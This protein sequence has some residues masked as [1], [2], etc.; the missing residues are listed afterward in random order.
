M[1]IQAFDTD[2]SPGELVNTSGHFGFNPDP[3]PPELEVTKLLSPLTEA[4]TALGRLQGIGSNIDNPRMLINPFIRKEAV[5]S[6]RIEGTRAT[7][8]DVYAYEAGD[9]D[10]VQDTIRGDVR[11]VLNYVRAMEQGL[12]A[13]ENTSITVDLIRS[14]H[15]T[16]LTG[17]RGEEKSPGEFRDRQNW[18]GTGYQPIE[19]ARYVPPPP[20]VVPYA[21]TELEEFINREKDIHPLIEIALV[22]YQFETIHPFIDGNG[23][24]G[25]LIISLMLRRRDL[26]PEPYLYLSS[27]F[28]ENREEYTDHLLSVSQCGGWEEWLRFFLIGVQHQ[29]DEAYDRAQQL[30]EIR[31][32]YQ[33]TYQGERSENVLKLAMVLFSQPYITVTE[34]ADRLDVAY[35]TANRAISTLESDGIV[36]ETTGQS[37]NRVFVATE[38]YDVFAEPAPDV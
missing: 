13:L 4:A 3:L 27:F 22:H 16:L 11:E 33:E 15:E 30:V 35:Q 19:E 10:S 5:L 21:M 17:V 9:G 31:K 14:L 18:I 8:A 34:A 37:R 38:I 24:L 2:R 23:R 1:D 28:N 25:R 36:S 12:A 20:S 6:S 29:A 26:L 32:R 7:L